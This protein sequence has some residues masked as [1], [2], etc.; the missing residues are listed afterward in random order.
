MVVFNETI[1]MFY[2]FCVVLNTGQ[3]PAPYNISDSWTHRNGSLSPNS[4][5]TSDWSTPGIFTVDGEPIVQK[6]PHS[7]DS[8]NGRWTIPIA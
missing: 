2:L 1:I 5:H 7:V 3:K 8:G 4:V 6:S